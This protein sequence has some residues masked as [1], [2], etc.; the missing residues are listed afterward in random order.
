M[1]YDGN[2]TAAD[3]KGKWWD[4]LDPQ[5][6]YSQNHAPESEPESAD[7]KRKLFNRTVDLIGKYH[8]DLL[9][10]DDDIYGGM[11]FLKQDP[12]W[13]LG[14]AADLYNT[15]MAQHGGKLEALI[16]AKKI[17]VAHSATTSST[18][19]S[20]A[21]RTTSC[22]NR[23][24]PTPAS[25]SGTTTRGWPSTTATRKARMSSARSPTSSA[26]TAT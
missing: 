1:P 7:Y 12:A 11:P 23:G 16:A 20:A 5:D 2:M 24:R 13:G 4:G 6:L 17:T 15:S 10:F 19:S 3:G 21:A 14:I 8:P 9:Y 22:P 25:A 18:T 26:R